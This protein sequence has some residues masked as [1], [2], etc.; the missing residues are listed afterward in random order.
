MCSEKCWKPTLLC[1]SSLVRKILDISS[2]KDLRH[3]IRYW[4]NGLAGGAQG[5][6]NDSQLPGA[7]EDDIPGK[8]IC[9]RGFT[10]GQLDGGRRVD[11]QRGLDVG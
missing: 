7:Q 9:R 10:G 6:E 8:G 1:Q 3:G 2:R 4:K 11:K 5:K